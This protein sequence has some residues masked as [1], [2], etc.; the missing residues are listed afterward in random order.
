[1]LCVPSMWQMKVNFAFS[2]FL[3][4][5]GILGWRVVQ[6]QKVFR[7]EVIQQLREFEN[8]VGGTEGSGGEG[9]MTSDRSAKDISAHLE[10]R[11]NRKLNELEDKIG[12]KYE[13]EVTEWSKTLVNK[14]FKMFSQNDEDGAIEA[15]FDFIGT[16]DKIYVEFGVETCIECNSRYLR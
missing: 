11:L 9:L 1:M 7:V 6:D 3:L 8:R 12:S 2:I 4:L 15:V 14:G 13:E 10:S 16:T 5:V